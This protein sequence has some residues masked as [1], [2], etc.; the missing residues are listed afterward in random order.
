MNGG[1]FIHICETEL[2][3]HCSFTGHRPARFPFGYDESDERCVKIKAVLAEQIRLLIESGVTV[4]YS[5][6]ALATDQW[7]A[8][9]VLEMKKLH[10]DLRL[11]AVRPCE[12][13]ANGWSE[14]QRKRYV[15][16]LALCDETI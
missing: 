12:T 2:S 15:D 14:A 7:A 4:F 5:G 16:T 3:R 10:P 11:V 8:E 6:M 9:I 1:L 13:Q